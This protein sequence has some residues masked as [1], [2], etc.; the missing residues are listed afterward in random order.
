MPDD[1]VVVSV[2]ELVLLLPIEEVEEDGDEDEY[3][4]E[5]VDGS[6]LVLPL[7]EPLVVPLAPIVDVL[8]AEDWGAGVL[9]EPPVL[10]S[11]V[12]AGAVALVPPLPA[13]AE[14]ELL[15]CATA[16]PPMASAA[17]AAN[18]VSVFLVVDMSF[19]P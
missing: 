15:V 19:A 16:K 10:W 6:V 9:D 8:L 7:T 3:V 4:D 13:F 5:E 2:D 14:S 12:L 18:V 11:V 1:D 17:A